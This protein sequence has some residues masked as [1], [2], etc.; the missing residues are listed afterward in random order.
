MKCLILHESEKRLRVHVDV[1]NMTLEEADIL[2]T[3][4]NKVEGVKKASVSD[5]TSD[6]IIEF[7]NKDNVIDALSSFH[8]ETCDVVPLN[9]SRS[10]NKEYEERVYWHIF[11]RI[12]NKLFL[13][14]PIRT[15]I[16]C[17]KSL[18][19]LAKG[20]NSLLNKKIEVSVLDATTIG[21][22]MLRS[23]FNTASSIMFLL[24]F[25]DI[26]EEWTHKK[27]ISDLAN[28]MSLH[29]DKVWML[30]SDNTEVLVSIN[31]IKKGDRIVVRTS[32]TIPLDGTII[33]GEINVNE[34]SMTGESLPVLKRKGSSVYAGTVVDEGECIIEV[35]NVSGSGRYDSIVKMIEESEK[36]KSNTEARAVHL[37]DRLVPYSFILTGAVYLFTQNITKALAVLMVDYSCALKLSMPI[38]VLSAIKEASYNH[39]SVKGGKFLEVISEANT[40][41]FDKTGTL[42]HSTPKVY[43][44]IPF[45]KLSSD[46]CL[47][48]AACLE[49]HFPHSIA[50][51]VIEAAKKR[52]LIHDK[53]V[54]AKVEYIVAHGIV[55]KIDN[56]RV[57]IGSYHFIF[58]DEKCKINKNRQKDFDNLPDEYSH[59]YLA[60]DGKLIAVILIED[61]IREEAKEVIAKLHDYGLDNVVMMTGDSNRTA[62]AVASKVGVDRYFSEVLPEDKANF[63]KNEHK[64]GRK[65]IMVGDGINDSPALSEADC[66]IAVSD[67]AAIA[68][69]IADI[70]IGTDDLYSLLKL[71]EISDLLMNRI[72]SNYRFIMSF[73]SLLIILGVL[74]ILPSTTTAY[75]HNASTLL[76]SMRSM[77]NLIKDDID[78]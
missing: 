17:V 34:S 5:R 29:I 73:N 71:K 66:G 63:I 20:A 37:S 22:S 10:I 52:D 58:E 76:I 16:T 38:S 3:Y 43:D 32:N 15:C 69:E 6:V 44:V 8:F 9:S 39:I 19:F 13:P 55:S 77:T 18:P 12:F 56:K 64:Q 72:N 33:S 41:V 70:T 27:S 60:M 50:N 59:L 67:G 31:D 65:V 26:L 35:K 24:G 4:L 36:L 28:A 30:T 75:I 45:D 62:K 49:E 48:I 68:R 25:S 74:G 54:H 57:A 61:P 78:D 2:E 46:E 14:L 11:S 21:V 51:A 53:E 23:D 1:L 7:N 47:R 42:T 40:I